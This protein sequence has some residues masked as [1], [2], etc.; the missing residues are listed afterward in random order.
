VELLA[1]SIGAADCVIELEGVGG[2]MRIQMKLT[3]PEVMSLV[4]DWREERPNNDHPILTLG[5]RGTA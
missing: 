5:K 3:A 4:R 1:G 2:R